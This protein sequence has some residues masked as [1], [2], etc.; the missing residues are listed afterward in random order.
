MITPLLCRRPP[1]PVHQI[2]NRDIVHH[3]ALKT[4][5]S[6]EIIDSMSFG[7]FVIPDLT[8]NPV[9]FWIPAFVGMTGLA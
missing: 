3:Q 1:N 8:R 7:R 9:F 5:K 4:V 2:S 6:L